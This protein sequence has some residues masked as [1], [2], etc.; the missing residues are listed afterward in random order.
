MIVSTAEICAFLTSKGLKRD[1]T[2]PYGCAG[3]QAENG[4]WLVIDESF[5]YQDTNHL[6]ED[7][8][9]NECYGTAA[10]IKTWE[11]GKAK[12]K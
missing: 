8:V 7:C 10:A 4:E 2:Q 1:D 11:D 12:Q 9:A 6:I 5:T 3:Y